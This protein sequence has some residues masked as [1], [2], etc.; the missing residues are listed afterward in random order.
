[1]NNWMIPVIY[2]ISCGLLY[3]L[4]MLYLLSRDKKRIVKQYNELYEAAIFHKNVNL[5]MVNGMWVDF[6]WEVP[7][8]YKG[9]AQ[10]KN[11]LWII[12]EV[13]KE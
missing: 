9:I 10:N 12:N 5:V 3:T 11:L 4:M 1:M 7:I 6:D 13:K 2:F 8:R